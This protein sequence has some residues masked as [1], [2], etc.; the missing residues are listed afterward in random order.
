[1]GEKKASSG[2]GEKSFGRPSVFGTE[3]EI[4]QRK[5]GREDHNDDPK[6]KRTKKVPPGMTTQRLQKGDQ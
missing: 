4:L 3:E 5:E 6:L 2:Y 1:V